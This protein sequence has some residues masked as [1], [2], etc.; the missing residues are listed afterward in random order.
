MKAEKHALMKW[1]E[2]EVFKNPN[3]ADTEKQ[4]HIE[5]SIKH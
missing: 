2:T 3:A 4:I 1:V 5:L